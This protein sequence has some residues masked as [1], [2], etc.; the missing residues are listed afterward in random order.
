MTTLRSM[1]STIALVPLRS[2]GEGKTRLAHLLEGQLRAELAG[3]MLADVVTALQAAAIDEVV[4]A[5]GGPAAAASA[6]ALNVEVLAD[7]PTVRSL[8]EAVAAAVQ[9]LGPTKDLL[10]VMADL[11]WLRPQDVTALLEAPGQAVIAPTCDGGTGGLL[12][13]PA[14]VLATSYGPGS[15]ERHAR[16]AALAGVP[17]TRCALQGF[18]RDLDTADDLAALLQRPAGRAT[19]RFTARHRELLSRT[20]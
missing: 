4:V 6:A 5:A 18:T 16:T 20:G 10:V 12:R 7:P 17:L 2:P 8:D 1:S 3:A 15:A 9:R 14:S 13:R 19:Q 11:P